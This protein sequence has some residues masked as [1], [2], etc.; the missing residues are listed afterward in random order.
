[1]ELRHA[2]A[3][4]LQE[5]HYRHDVVPGL[6]HEQY[7]DE[8]LQAINWLTRIHELRQQAE[9]AKQKQSTRG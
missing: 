6:T 8:P 7:L 4:W 2:E 9:A 3:Q 1:M 5:Y